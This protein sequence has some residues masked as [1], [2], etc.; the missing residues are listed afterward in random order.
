MSADYS[1]HTL[2]N[3]LRVVHKRVAGTR[4]VHCGF[5][6]GAGSRNDGKHPGLAHCLEHMLFKGTGKRKTVHILNHLEVVGGE[7]NA[8]T[9]KELTA[10]YATVQNTHF[11]RAVD[12]LSDVTFHSIIP[13]AELEKEKKVIADE[14]NMYLDT[15]EENIYDEFQE[16]VFRQHP[17]AH[18][19]LGNKD[20]VHN[21]QRKH[22]ETF[23]HKHYSPA[24]MVFVVVG[25]ISL[26]RVLYQAEKYTSHIAAGSGYHPQQPETYTYNPLSI[27]TETD[28]A[29]AY[30]IMGMPAYEESHAKRWPMLLLNNLLGGPGM[31]S[32]LNLAIREKYGY[33][34]QIESGY[35]SY[36]DAGM[37]HCY[38]SCDNRYLRKST[39]LILKE[40]DLLKNKKLGTLQLSRAKNQF[41]GQMVMA[42]ENR[43]GL[44]VHLGKGVLRHGRALS[45]KEVLDKI[46]AIT[47]EELQETAQEIFNSSQFSYLTYVPA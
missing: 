39:D 23:V 29:G 30:T 15:P 12:I 1:L 36:S 32:R 31:N 28:F 25:N 18:N 33:T 47:A 4:L 20:S 46:D 41:M 3:G 10:I 17:I 42:E 9:T 40:L 37:F 5:I 13:E 11:A 24:N 45:L 16:Q 14:I 34:Y 7:M 19:I 26:N 6:I 21:I 44:L 27:T 35:Q 43:S 8:F 38:L 22:I 2:K